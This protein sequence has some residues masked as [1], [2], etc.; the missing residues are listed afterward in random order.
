MVVRSL[1]DMDIAVKSPNNLLDFDQVD[2]WRFDLASY[3]RLIET[4]VLAEDDRVELIDGV[5][6]Q[7][8]VGP[9][10]DCV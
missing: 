4:G 8:P 7:K 6:L 1:S 10:F 3:H 2:V 5:I 9:N